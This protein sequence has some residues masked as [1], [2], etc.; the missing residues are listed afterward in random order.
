M[1][2]NHLLLSCP[3]LL[4]PSLFPSIRVFFNELA[5]GHEVAKVSILCIISILYINLSLQFVPPLVFFL[6]LNISFL[7]LS[8]SAV[9]LA[10]IPSAFTSAPVSGERGDLSPALGEST[11][12]S[13][14]LFSPSWPL[15]PYL[16]PASLPFVYQLWVFVGFP[17][18]SLNMSAFLLSWDP[19]PSLFPSLSKVS[20]E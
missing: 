13:W 18:W 9:S 4:L 3:L 6:W 5:L 10:L 16:L 8:A 14:S 12:M 2:S 11:P 19:L 20:R 17:L 15:F 7:H 1:P